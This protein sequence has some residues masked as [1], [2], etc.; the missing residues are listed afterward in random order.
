MANNNNERKSKLDVMLGAGQ[1]LRSYGGKFLIT[2]TPCFNIDKVRWSAVKIGSGGDSMDFYMDMEKFTDLCECEFKFGRLI[3]EQTPAWKRLRESGNCDTRR[4]GTGTYS[5]VTGENGANHLDICNGSKGILVRVEVPAANGKA[6]EG[7]DFYRMSA[8]SFDDLKRMAFWY[9]IVSGLRDVEGYH[10]KKFNLF[11]EAAEKFQG[12]NQETD[13][14]DRPPVPN[15]PAE[16]TEAA[17]QTKELLRWARNVACP[18]TR[19]FKN[20]TLGQ[21]VDIGQNTTNPNEAKTARQLLC[22]LA[23]QTNPQTEEA[24]EAAKVIV[25]AYAINEPMDNGSQ[26]KAPQAPQQGTY[27]QPVQQPAN[28]YTEQRWY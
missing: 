9:E 23:K 3:N 20:L 4:H 19:Q 1:L 24:T 17:D 14:S 28:G 25:E 10:K 6:A 18:P 21:I 13:F 11:F 5:Y 12:H 16:P 22:Y 27:Q 26:Q 15:E 2:V 8:V 7:R